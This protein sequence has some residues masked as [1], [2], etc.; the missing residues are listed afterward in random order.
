MQ[1]LLRKLDISLTVRVLINVLYVIISHL[2]SYFALTLFNVPFLH[3]A[4]VTM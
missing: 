4:A 1:Y 3:F 2:C